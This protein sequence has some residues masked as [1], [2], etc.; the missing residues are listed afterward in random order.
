MWLAAVA[1]AVALLP[2]S[3]VPDALSSPLS[4]LR[5]RAADRVRERRADRAF[6]Q[7]DLPAASPAPDAPRHVVCVVVDALRADAVTP[8]LTPFLHSLAPERAV[9]P[10]TWTFP[11]VAS[12][13][14]GLYPHRHG[15]IRRTDDYENAVADVTPLPPP[16]EATTLP[17][18]LAGAGYDTYGGFGMLVPFLALS[19]RFGTHRLRADADATDVLADHESWLEGREDGRTFSYL[20][21][22]DLHE[23]VD[24]PADYW[25]T[26]DVDESI[27]G[28]RRWRHEDVPH[29]TPTV[30]RYREHRTR[31]Y[32]A[33]AE[34]VD[35]RLAAHH[36]RLTDRLGDVL[37][38]V[39][40]D[41][42]EG[43]WER[44]AFHAAHFADSR[45]AYCVGHGG[46][47]YEVI[48]R[49]PLAFD[50]SGSRE[51]PA[52]DARASLVDVAPTLRDAAGLEA[53]GPGADPGRDAD[54][55][56]VSGT[57]GGSKVAGTAGRSGASGTAGGPEVSG[58]AGGL[59]PAG[60]VSLF[61]PV[62]DRRLLVE[63]ARYGY[64]KKAVYDGDR[65]LVVSHGDDVAAGFSL[66]E[67]TT[68]ELPRPVQRSMRAAL[69]PWPDGDSGAGGERVSKEARRR[70]EDL[71]YT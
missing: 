56:E 4:T 43:F 19:G 42:G 14:T 53:A 64:E 48:T 57:A 8:D 41:H 45:P 66:P 69:P 50:A 23:P 17:E 1:S 61:D 29:L 59:T 65:K 36:A 31:L 51:V 33:A 54:A 7:R 20:H 47:P 46:A 22:G 49:V 28:V 62:P 16:P 71:G 27:P 30:E 67:E 11:A 24:P 6:R 32:E 58:T 37:F 21:L 52:A 60:G 70:L 35:G 39:A 44:A 34:Y 12:L 13:L 2:E 10:S 25:A 9:S 3:V 55:A 26:H 18:Q 40:G 38:V 68:L 5:T 63:G 15:A